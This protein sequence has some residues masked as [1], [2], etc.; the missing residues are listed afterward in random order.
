MREKGLG[1]LC[2]NFCSDWAYL[3]FPGLGGG[4]KRRPRLPSPPPLTPP[5]PPPFLKN[6]TRYRH[7][8]YTTNQAS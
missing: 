4:V 7:E 2:R 6:Y 1:P 3:V 5:L 8:T